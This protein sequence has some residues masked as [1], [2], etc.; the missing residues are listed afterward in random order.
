[1]TKAIPLIG[2]FMTTKPI[3]IEKDCN[4]LEA[5]KLMQQNNIRHLPVTYQNKVE[6]ILSESDITLVRG[7]KDVHIEKMKVYDCYTPNPFTVSPDAPLDKVLE[8]MAERKY[9]SVVVVDNQK[10]VGV[11]TWVDALIATA[12]L[13]HTRLK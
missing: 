4:L 6:G 13:L 11:F 8:E 5:A 1:M 7:L 2:K 12:E 10:L 9:G 3:S